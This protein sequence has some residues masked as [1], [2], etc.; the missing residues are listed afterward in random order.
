L[1]RPFEACDVLDVGCGYGDTTCQLALT[2]RSVVGVEP[3]SDLAAQ[4]NRSA[5]AN[6]TIR[7]GTAEALTE[8]EAYDLVVLDNVYEHVSDHAAALDGISRALRPGGVLYLLV[9]NRAWPIEAHYRL[10]FL[11][12]LPLR[13][14]NVYL[15][16]SG[17]GSDYTDASYAPTLR[18]LARD[19]SRHP[20]LDWRFVLPGDPTATRSGLPLH[21][22]IGMKGLRVLPPLWAISKAFLVIAVKGQE[23]TYPRASTRASDS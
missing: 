2:A 1:P 8:V 7:Q 10:P 18:S 14:A 22:R 9:P 17:R 20:E 4:A 11:A 21:Y 16:A 23:I 15:R 13:L 6:V 19:L 12:W 5:P 3:A